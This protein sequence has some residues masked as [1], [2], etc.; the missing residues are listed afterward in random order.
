[1]KKLRTKIKIQQRLEE[2]K[3][4]TEHRKQILLKHINGMA[5]V[6]GPLK[7]LFVQKF[8]KKAL[9]YAKI[10]END[11]QI[12]LNH[13]D[14]PEG[15]TEEDCFF[16]ITFFAN[17]KKEKIESID[18]FDR[19]KEGDFS[20]KFFGESNSALKREL[21]KNRLTKKALSKLLK[22][23][24]GNPIVTTNINSLKLELGLVFDAI[25]ENYRWIQ[26]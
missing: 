12:I 6:F 1:V 9:E 20:L 2:E 23:L 26:Q 8:E 10:P 18:L 5:F 21:S 15:I 25:I 11:L 14:D 4:K 22:K 13:F 19:N 7:N 3:Q 16:Q 24:E 17:Q